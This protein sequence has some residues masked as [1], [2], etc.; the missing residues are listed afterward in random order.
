MKFK[1]EDIMFWILIALI[2]GIAIWKLVGSPTDT[3][4]L[5]SVILFVAT[6]E[7]LIWRKIFEI[8][9]KTSISF[10]KIGNEVKEDIH[11]LD[12]KLEKLNTLVTK[13]L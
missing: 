6:S 5:I 12:V 2:V 13:K 11:K 10:I 3:A 7:I 1:L 8:E 9:K 4:T